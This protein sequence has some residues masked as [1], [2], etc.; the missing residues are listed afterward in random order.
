MTSKPDRFQQLREVHLFGNGE[1]YEIESAWFHSGRL[2]LKF[3]GIDS[4]SDAERL[5]G[6]EVR[7]PREQRAVL[8]PGEYYHSDLVGC[9]IIERSTGQSLGR[10]T[11]WEDY[12]GAGLLAVEGGL[13][14]PF[15]ASICTHIDLRARR[16]FVDL[17][18]GL[19]ELNR[20]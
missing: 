20:D 19:K 12:G 4:I 2:I 3:R 8:E 9:E 17:P 11:A 7:I 10:V 5:Q 1:R 18:E 13:L 15:A 14:I 6:A 16:I